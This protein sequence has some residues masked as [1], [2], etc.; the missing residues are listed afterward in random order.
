[1][2]CTASHVSQIESGQTSVTVSKIL[3]AAQYLSVDPRSIMIGLA[4]EVLELAETLSPK[5][6]AQASMGHTQEVTK[7]VKHLLGKPQAQQQKALAAWK[8]VLEMA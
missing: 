5:T 8:A 3:L 6:Q 1:M 7:L 2:G 4:A